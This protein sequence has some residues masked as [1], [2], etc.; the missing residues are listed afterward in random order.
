[1]V[2]VAV[3]PQHAAKLLATHRATAPLAA[4]IA[5]YAFEPIGTVYAA[6]PPEL[7]LPLPMLGLDGGKASAIGQ[8]V[9]DR[10]SLG[11]AAGLLSFVLSGH[12]AWQELANDALL[13][14]LHGE[15]EATLGRQLPFPT[16][17]CIIRER[18]AT[19]SCRPKLVRPSAET[20]IP[21]LWLA[22]DYVCPDYP[23]TLEAAVRSGVAAARAI[24]QS[25]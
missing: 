19:Y 12:G 16:W 11:D 23:A 2:I 5:A 15:L 14:C 25:R 1:Q 8:W 4:R 6:Y 22:G 3:A 20:A 13:T 21:G 24:M 18:R 7:R 9:F 10:G 17:H